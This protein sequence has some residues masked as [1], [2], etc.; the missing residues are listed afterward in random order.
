MRSGVQCDVEEALLQLWFRISE[1]QSLFL[2]IARLLRQNQIDVGRGA[3]AARPG[4]ASRRDGCRSVVFRSDD[5]S[6]LLLH[7]PY[8]ATSHVFVL[9]R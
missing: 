2:V 5:C 3:R 4:K 7:P 8:L 6:M 1:Q 9:S